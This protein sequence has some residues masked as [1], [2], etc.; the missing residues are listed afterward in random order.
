MAAPQVLVVDDEPDIRDLL[1][2]TLRRMGINCRTAASLREARDRL[3]EQAY[4]LCLTDMRLPDGNGI[5]LVRYIQKRFPDMPTA[6]ITAYGNMDT[7][8]EAMKAGAFDFVP[9]PLDVDT[10]RQVVNQ[11]LKLGPESA[12]DR[13]SRDV[14]LGDS[15]AMRRIRGMIVKLA[16]S[17]APVYIQGPS[18]TG[19]ELVARLIHD[20][21]PRRD[22]PFVPVNCGAIPSEL[23][24]SEFFGHKKGA[25]T[26]AHADHKGLFQTAEGGT[27][28]LDEVAELPLP[29]QVKL[30]R[31]IQE[32]R[33]RPVGAS[34]EV[35]VDVRILSATHQ[36]LARRVA[37]GAFREDLY[38]RLNVIP[39]SIP[40]LRER[41]ED[42]PPLIDHLLEKMVGDDPELR[43]RLTT[44][45]LR[46]LQRHPFRGNVRELEN[47]LERALTLADEGV[48]DVEDLH[49]PDGDA[50]A[51]A[52]QN[53]E[54]AIPEP[55]EGFELEG[56]LQDLERTA[57]QRALAKTNG[58]KTAAAN[59]LGIS[60]RSLRYKLKKLEME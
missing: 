59:L 27:L 5:E 33:V 51:P 22:G 50:S 21:G 28:F 10:L 18:G 23:M 53:S 44:D 42:I 8:V 3:Q 2:I 43:P 60:F 6:V 37:E 31:A 1:G 58:N 11:A 54:L 49:L 36:D 46:A 13:R 14:L 40:P 35:P 9:K 47:I 20:K 56:Y 41:P 32:K 19:K 24:E 48:I 4:D 7:A 34:K 26:G 52:Q 45:A 17:Q 16:R 25:F 38:Y 57:I 55:D 15:E 12:I 29:M 39:L 30:L